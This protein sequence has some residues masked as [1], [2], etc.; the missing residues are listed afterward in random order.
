MS[1]DPF[2]SQ[3]DKLRPGGGD[4]LVTDLALELILACGPGSGAACG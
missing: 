4:K 1:S 3:A 2:I